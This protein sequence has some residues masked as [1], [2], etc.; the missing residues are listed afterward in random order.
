MLRV[1][2]AS[3]KKKQIPSDQEADCTNT[4]S[5][6]GPY[7][8]DVGKMQGVDTHQDQ[9]RKNARDGECKGGC[10]VLQSW[11]GDFGACAM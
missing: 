11:L 1:A 2:T 8:C 9:W 7:V 4:V 5:Y 3:C 6:N 10:I